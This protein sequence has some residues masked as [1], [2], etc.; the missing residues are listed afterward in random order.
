MNSSKECAVLFAFMCY[1]EMAELH[2]APLPSSMTASTNQTHPSRPQV[3][4]RLASFV[5]ASSH[6][7]AVTP[8]APLVSFWYPLH[9]KIIVHGVEEPVTQDN[10]LCADEKCISEADQTKKVVKKRARIKHAKSGGQY[11]QEGRLITNS[12]NTSSARRAKY[13]HRNKSSSSTEPLRFK[14]AALAINTYCRASG[15]M[16]K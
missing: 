15:R 1:V 9:M 4:H 3:L 5:A 6:H 14:H 16:K 11:Q 2:N 13:P 7:L 8:R 12:M 10:A